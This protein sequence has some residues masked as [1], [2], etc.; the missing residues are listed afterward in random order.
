M[1]YGF[2]G[3]GNMASAIIRGA[4]ASGA[5]AAEDVFGYNHHIEKAEAL[6]RTCGMRV[7]ESLAALAAKSDFIVLAVKPQVLPDVLPKL[8]AHVAGKRIVTIAAGKTLEYYEAA[9]GEIPVIRVMPNINAVV[10]ASTSCIC[11]NAH[12]SEAD[13]AQ[14]RAL[15]EAVGSVTEI[16][17]AHFSVFGSVAGCSPAYTFMYIDALARAGVRA[18]LSRKVAQQAAASAVMGSARMALESNEHPQALADKVCS[19]GGSTIE[20]LYALQ[21]GG[22]EGLVQQAIAA[23]IEKS[24]KL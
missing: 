19:P 22:F 23:A 9:L 18:G 2:I 20:G 15:F 12:A 1:R 17:E 16:P 11:A 24:A 10:G 3:L 8:K 7:C 13:V 5:V 4:I 6:S 21:L 14:V